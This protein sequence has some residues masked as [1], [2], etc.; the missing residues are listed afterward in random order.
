MAEIVLG[1]A[2]SHGPMLSTTPE[3]WTLR[4]PS[5]RAAKHPFHGLTW[6]FQEL[7]EHRRNEQ[8]DSQI[9]LDVMRAPRGLPAGA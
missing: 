7:V 3:Q 5:D 8:F 6:S 1:M 9:T 2:L 4:V